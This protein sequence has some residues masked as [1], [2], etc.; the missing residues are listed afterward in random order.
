MTSEEENGIVEQ[1]ETQCQH[2]DHMQRCVKEGCKSIKKRIES[3][4]SGNSWEYNTDEPEELLTD[5]I[6]DLDVLLDVESELETLREA[7]EGL[8]EWGQGWKDL[9]QRFAEELDAR[10]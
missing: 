1:P 6:Y 9:D 7:V 10:E 3:F 2:I 4:T 8:R 5:I